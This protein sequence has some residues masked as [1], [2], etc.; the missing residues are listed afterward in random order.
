MR[1]GDEGGSEEMKMG[2]LDQAFLEVSYET[3][4]AKRTQLFVE[5]VLH[6]AE[7]KRPE[8]RVSVRRLHLKQDAGRSFKPAWCPS[9]L[10]QRLMCTA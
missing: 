1:V 10:N 5:L 4:S 6:R 7:R 2:L 3:C 9:Y 8:M